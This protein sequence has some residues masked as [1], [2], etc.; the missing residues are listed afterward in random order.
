M[1]GANAIAIKTLKRYFHHSDRYSPL[2]SQWLL[3]NADFTSLAD[4]D[5]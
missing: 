3:C 2:F 4:L 5:S 1:A